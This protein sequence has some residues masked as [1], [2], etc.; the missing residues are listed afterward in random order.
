MKNKTRV[1]GFLLD[2]TALIDFLRGNKHTLALLEVL[3]EKAHLAACPVTVAEVFSGAREN[4][5][6]VVEQFLSSLKFYP[7]D[8][9]SSRLAGRWRYTYTRMGIT[10]SLPDTLIAAVALRNNLALVTANEKHYPMEDLI[11]ITH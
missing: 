10:F 4:E 7:I 6:P 1:K 2:T 3:A 8:Y 9:E 11:I 5:L